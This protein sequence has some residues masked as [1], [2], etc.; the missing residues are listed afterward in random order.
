MM[1]YGFVVALGAI[2]LIVQATIE[3]INTGKSFKHF[4]MPDC[5]PVLVLG[6]WAAVCGDGFLRRQ[7]W[8]DVS[9]AT[10]VVC[11]LVFSWAFDWLE[12]SRLGGVA[13][14]GHFGGGCLAVCGVIALIRDSRKGAIQ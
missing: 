9:F 6:C 8:A 5:L 7:I 3:A 4:L 14:A 13:R 11:Y 10:L 12:Y 2:V 1:G